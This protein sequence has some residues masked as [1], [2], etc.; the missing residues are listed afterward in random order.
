MNI[1]TSIL[2]SGGLCFGVHTQA[3]LCHKGL[4]TH[5]TILPCVARLM[6]KDESHCLL[7][8]LMS[9]L[10]SMN[11]EQG[12]CRTCICSWLHF[13]MTTNMLHARRFL[14]IF[15]PHHAWATSAFKQIDQ[16]ISLQFSPFGKLSHFYINFILI[17]KFFN[18]ISCM[19]I[20]QDDLLQPVHSVSFFCFTVRKFIFS[21]QKFYQHVCD[22]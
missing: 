16:V 19:Y 12:K 17:N 21:I 20:L 9:A 13:L 18:T 22:T 1:N 2:V 3:F 14:N 4:I 6:A 10:G 11:S 8:C 15:F 7:G 5:M